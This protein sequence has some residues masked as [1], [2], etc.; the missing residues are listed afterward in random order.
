M[1]EDLVA[2]CVT[3]HQLLPGGVTAAGMI[4]DELP[5]DADQWLVDFR[6]RAGRS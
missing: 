6:F 4:P 1:A 2:H 3:A 5:D